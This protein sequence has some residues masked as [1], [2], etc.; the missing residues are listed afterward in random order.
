MITKMSMKLFLISTLIPPVFSF[1][2]VLTTQ[3]RNHLEEIM[4]VQISNEQDRVTIKN[5]WTEVH[6]IAEFL[7]RPEALTVIQKQEPLADKVFLGD[8]KQDSLI[9]HS[10]IRLTG[11]GQY[12]ISESKWIPFFFRCDLSSVTGKV[13]RFVIDHHTP[14]PHRNAILQSN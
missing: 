2:S 6:Q 12:R 13:T 5:D 7:C 10:P 1:A 11:N 8:E 4:S 9:L 3:Q 14:Y